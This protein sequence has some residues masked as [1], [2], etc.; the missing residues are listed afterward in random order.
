[1]Q[2]QNH[3]RE[4]AGAYYYGRYG[5]LTGDI[6]TTPDQTAVRLGANGG[7]IAVD[8]HVFAT[9]RLTDSFA[10]AE[11][12][13]YGNIGVG[14]GNNMLTKTD[15]KGIALIPRL[16]AYQSNSI[17]LDPQDLPVSAELDSIER[18]VVPAWRSGVKVSFPVRSGRGALL[19]IQLEDGEPAPAG[20][21][22][23]IEDDKQEFYVARRGEAFVTGLQATNHIL[24]NWKEQQCKF[25][26][27]LP[28]EKPDEIPR[29]GPLL[30]K[31][32]TR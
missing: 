27:T 31:G 11:V 26:V 23:Q 20:A 22:V 3:N 8:G 17:R 5:T 30:C 9:Q 4:E 18:D 28:P 29:L 24:L 6:S 15:V 25:N 21:I 13:D 32:I 10:L 14:I 19:K 7:L 12:K 2:Q 16:S 1:G